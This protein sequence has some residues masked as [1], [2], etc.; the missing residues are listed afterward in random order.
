MRSVDRPLL[1]LLPEP[2]ERFAH[3]ALVEELLATELAV[4]ADPPRVSYRRQVAFADAVAPRQA[5]RLRKRLKGDPR[6]VVI[7]AASQYPLARWLL[8]LLPDGELWFEHSAEPDGER[9][10]SLRRMAVERARLRFDASDRE[11]LEEAL[12]RLVAA[13]DSGTDPAT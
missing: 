7:F 6:V 12:Q 1:L 3:R 10:A 8:Q 13:N 4:A 9:E 5:K 11:V 2:L